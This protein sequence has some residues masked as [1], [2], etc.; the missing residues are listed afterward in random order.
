MAGRPRSLPGQLGKVS[1]QSRGAT[2]I[3]RAHVRDAGGERHRLSASGA[4]ERQARERLEKRAASYA[5][6]GELSEESTLAELLELWVDD[7]R[8]QVRHQTLRIYADTVRWLTPFAGSLTVAQLRPAA[9]RAVLGRVERERSAS[10]AHHARVAISGAMALA[11]E[12]DVIRQNPVR[13]LRPRAAVVTMP[14]ALNR[15]G[16]TA[17]REAIL[18]R[19][20]RVRATAG[21]CAPMLRWVV[22]VQLGSGL[23]LAEVLAL[24][25]MDYNADTGAISVTGTLVDDESGQVVR[26]PELKSRSQARRILLPEFARVALR[27]ALQFTPRGGSRGGTDPLIQGRAP[28]WIPPRSLRR[29]FRALRDDD[30]LASALRELDFDVDQLTPHVLRRTAGT[31]LAADSGELSM[32]QALLGHSDI[33]T[34][35]RHYAGAAFTTVGYAADLDRLLG[36]APHAP[37][38]VVPVAQASAPD[39]DV[40]P[41]LALVESVATAPKPVQA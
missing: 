31:A 7:R 36:P 19:E 28:G 34:T 6:T 32:A 16:V 11:V 2:F 21:P 23:R 14:L 9:V 5:M 4:T 30:V 3:A 15:E 24:R 27:E 20:A 40:D 39:R 17:V 29:S 37:R 12:A 10:A 22:E 18:R 13:S 35:R 33:G 41:D 26:Q 8:G 25:M 38:S 1:I